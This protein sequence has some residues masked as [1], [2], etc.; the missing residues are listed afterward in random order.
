MVVSPDHDEDIEAVRLNLAQIAA[1]P[2]GWRARAIS[3]GGFLGAAAAVTLWSLAQQGSRVVGAVPWVVAGAA[4]CYLLAVVVLLIAS[5]LP[6]PKFDGANVVGAANQL[7]ASA[8]QESGRIKGAV[9]LGA[10]LGSTAIILTSVSIFLI[11]MMPVTERAYVSFSDAT[12][13]DAAKILCPDLGEAFLA[14]VTDG[15]PGMVRV[16]VVGNTCP[17]GRSELVVPR[18]AIVQAHSEK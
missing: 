8:T 4:L 2:D 10:A 16:S 13:R 7:H 11:L 17:D 12:E 1:A 9:F 15:G 18:M 14:E 6:P 5:I 3:A